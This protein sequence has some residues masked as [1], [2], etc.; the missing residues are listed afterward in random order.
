MSRLNTRP[1]N[2]DKH[3]GI[4]DLSPQR[5]TPVQKKADDAK[6]MEEKQAREDTHKA[7]VR[8]LANVEQRAMQKLKALM[9]PGPGP[10]LSETTTRGELATADLGTGKHMHIY[11]NVV[12]YYHASRATHK[13]RGQKKWSA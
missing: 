1:N 2:K 3:P 5:R 8:Q 11:E 13:N 12:T 7:G 10:R 9:T 6:A 4:V